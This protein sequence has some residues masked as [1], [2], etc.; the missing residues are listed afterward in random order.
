[1]INSVLAPN[2][3][4]KILAC[5]AFLVYC[6]SSKANAKGQ[7]HLKVKYGAQV[8]YHK[9]HSILLY[10]FG[11]FKCW[12]DITPDQFIVQKL[13]KWPACAWMYLCVWGT[14]NVRDPCILILRPFQSNYTF[15]MRQVRE[16]CIMKK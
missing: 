8:S 3:Y 6:H 12:L 7:G 2:F 15:C 5:V 4:L 16:E 9:F 13:I 10:D 14:Y 1:M 11:P